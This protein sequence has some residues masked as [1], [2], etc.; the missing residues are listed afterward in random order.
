M[1]LLKN[2][3]ATAAGALVCGLATV[4]QAIPVQ[5]N[6]AI[7]FQGGF[8]L[9]GSDFL[10]AS[11]FSGFNNVT[12]VNGSTSGDYSGA[13]G[14]SVTFMPFTFS[15]PD[16]SVSPLWSF[17]VGGT[18]YTFDASSVAVPF[19]TATVLS[20][21]GAG[22]A[23]IDGFTDTPGTWNIT[24]NQLGGATFSFSS[25]AF[26]V[27]PP[28]SQVPDGGVTLIM[29]GGGLLALAAVRRTLKIA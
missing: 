18:A 17:M 13:D 22:V 5:I 24:A 10:G 4:A 21:E 9:N 14:T 3:R 25:S 11:M 28:S 27:D 23:H 15:P 12:V 20:I 6:G 16:T 7:S 26:V 8:S 2:L 1:K 29:L 19:K